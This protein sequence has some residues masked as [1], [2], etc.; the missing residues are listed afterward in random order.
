[1]EDAKDFIRNEAKGYYNCVWIVV[2]AIGA[3]GLVFL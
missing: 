3:L 2:I 1:M